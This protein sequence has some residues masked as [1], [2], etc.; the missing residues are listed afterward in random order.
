MRAI[1]QILLP[2]KIL[3]RY[4]IFALLLFAALLS[5][6]RGADNAHDAQLRTWLQKG[7][8]LT[9]NEK[10]REKYL[11]SV[12]EALSNRVNDTVT[13]SLYSKVA[14]AYFNNQDL[15][16]SVEA[17]KKMYALAENARDTTAMGKAAYLQGT[18][19][20]S[21]GIKDGALRLYQKAEKLFRKTNHPDL[22]KVILF[23]AYIFHDVGEFVLCESEASE[24]LKLLRENKLNYEVYQCQVIIALALSE[25]D[26]PDEAIKYYQR[27]LAQIETF[28]A[29]LFTEND[30][31]SYRAICYYNIGSVYE[32]S[33]NYPQAIEYYN[34]AMNSPAA[35]DKTQ[36][37]PR[38]VASLAHVRA[39]M[40]EKE[41]VENMIKGALE[42]SR[43]INDQE[44]MVLDYISLAN[45]YALSH[46]SVRASE[47]FLKAYQEAHVING[48]SYKLKALKGLSEYSKENS[49]YFSKEYMK[50]DDSLQKTS[51]HN[52]NKYARIEYETDQLM[53]E[54]EALVR[55]NS[56]IIGVSVV[57]LLFV[58][59]IF[60]IY[61]LNS[62]NKE[63]VMLQEQQQANEEI[64]QLM[65]E[66]QQ[67][68]ESART[69]EK[70]RIAMELHDGVLNNIYAVRLNL[71]FS[72]R[73]NDEVAVEKRKEYIKELQSLEAE[74]RSVSHDLSRS[75]NLVQGKDFEDMLH[76]L[77]DTQKNNFGTHFDLHIDETVNWDE[78]PNTG[79]VN[80]YRIIQECL[81]NVNKYSVAENAWVAI[82]KDGDE[83]ILHVKDDGVGFDTK[84]ASEGIGLKNLRQRATALNGVI[85]IAS[86]P[87]KGTDI[88][89]QFAV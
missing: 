54:K 77:V 55:K 62:R 47:S 20:Y 80:V 10:T 14:A 72:N 7:E 71:E 88:V 12:T 34:K 21:N 27:A 9:V 81:Q 8:T 28:D 56:F 31:E 53:G 79:K 50:L 22:G 5:C 19:L 17:S 44:G 39:L 68:V 32:K 45:F 58:A 85:S 73:K 16:K 30:K 24:A 69:E 42:N 84:E 64:Y 51:A 11:D 78:L 63:L 52:R 46:D 35:T 86:A 40:G 23:K 29:N 89:V 1:V 57:V 15:D 18:V 70:N 49:R 33:K 60:I 13:R 2:S 37:Y 87:G 83:I 67:R 66:Q 75:A 38:T 74:I 82:N 43:K 4:L 76:F 36:L 25:Q 41:G 59:A 26:N 65:F 3:K 61:Y 6:N 48:N